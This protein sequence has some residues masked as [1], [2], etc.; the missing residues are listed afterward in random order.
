MNRQPEYN[1]PAGTVSRKRALWCIR[2]PKRII[3]I[4]SSCGMHNFSCSKVSI[5][6]DIE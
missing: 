2:D 4:D 1:F 5:R 3:L 6:V